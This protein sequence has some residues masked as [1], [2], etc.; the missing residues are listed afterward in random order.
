MLHRG[1]LGFPKR[2]NYNDLESEGT[3]FEPGEDAMRSGKLAYRSKLAFG[4]VAA[5]GGLAVPVMAQQ[6]GEVLTRQHVRPGA[7]SKDMSPPTVQDNARV[8]ASN[9]NAQ[10][11]DYYRKGDLAGVVSVYTPDATYVQLLPRMMVMKGRDQIQQHM[12]ELM[13]AKASDLVLTVTTAHVTGTDRIMV[14]GDYYVMVE[15]GKKVYGHFFQA[16]RNEGGTWKIAM[17]AFAR[18]EPVTA[19]EA[20]EYHVGG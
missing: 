6:A 4:I 5:I 12:R 15:G 3:E 17:H 13:A 9:V 16:L 20:S 10:R 18:P 7:M 1:A 19:I 11:S 14:G 2:T 8:V